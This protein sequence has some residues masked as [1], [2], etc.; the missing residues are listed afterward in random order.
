MNDFAMVWRTAASASGDALPEYRTNTAT[1]I[2][3]KPPPAVN[4]R[5]KPG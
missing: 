2:A 4:P 5:E 3:G 1:I